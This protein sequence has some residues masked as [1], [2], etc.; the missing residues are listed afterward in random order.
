MAETILVP[1]KKHDRIEE[2]IP[3]IAK[4]AQP[5]ASVVFLV[6]HS[7]R[8][9]QWLQA[10]C[11]IALCGLEKA[12]VITRLVESYSR[13]ARQQLARRRVFET[14]KALH[15]LHLN[16]AVEVYTGRLR[17]TL[18]SYPSHGHAQLLVM[19]PGI[20]QRIMNILCGAGSVADVFAGST[21]SATLL[22]QT[23]E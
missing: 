9:F 13:T 7:V 12:L 20:G 22:L 19:R 11:G 18:A 17:K 23:G 21:S 5:G 14:C 10:Y 2:M 6:H 1:L 16:I 8:G 3:Y 15:D 4:V